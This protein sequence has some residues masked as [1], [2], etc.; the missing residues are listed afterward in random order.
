MR[1]RLVRLCV[2][3]AA[4]A[5][6]AASCGDDD[7]GG[8]SDSADTTEAGESTTSAADG[9]S[10]TAAPDE[11]STSA[12]D[13]EDSDGPDEELTASAPGIT[14]D[15]IKIGISMLDFPQL[16]S[17][18]LSDAGWGDQ[19]LIWESIIQDV[20]DRGGINGRM[21]EAELQYYLP[22]D[23]AEIDATC[24]KFTQDIDVFAVLGGI[25]GS[26]DAGNVCLAEDPDTALIAGSALTYERLEK[27]QAAWLITGGAEER[28]LENLIAVLDQEGEL[29]GKKVAVVTH[30]EGGPAA[31]AAPDLLAEYGVDPVLTIENN[32][33]S[34]DIPA[35]DAEW[36]VIAEQIISSDAD[37]VL[38]LGGL[39]A[40]VRGIA[41]NALDVA[42]WTPNNGELANMGD[43]VTPADAD[44]ALTVTGLTDAEIYDDPA[45]EEC[46]ERFNEYNPD[47]EVIPGE[48]VPE[49]DEEWHL[50][51]HNYCRWFALF[52]MVMTAAG[53][54]PTQESF[55]E[56]AVELGDFTLPGVPFASLGPDKSDA[57]DGYR[58][59]A[60]DSS[61]GDNGDYRPLSD[62]VDTT[63]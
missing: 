24:L 48:D 43:S 5:L 56:A 3:L 18:G 26:L 4:F 16:I 6:L 12:P 7:D 22:T 19:E 44:G 62:I 25:L 28:L 13:G 8:S 33:P 14:E 34:G 23:Q 1:L 31:E 11:S 17:L 29:E 60:F 51:V 49:G 15:T 10:T 37:T 55:A 36:A 21:V 32:A 27:A 9:S 47:I 35:G 58:L 63:S 42:I 41:E 2:I 45:S 59:S 46:R 53:P 54:N 52:E 38:L 39:T 61:I 50:G 57:N 40:G 30:L 20:N